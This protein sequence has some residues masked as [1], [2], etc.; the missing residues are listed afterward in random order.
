MRS[1]ASTDGAWPPARRTAEAD[2]PCGP[3]DQPPLD[4]RAAR[5]LVPRVERRVDP[6]EHRLAEQRRDDDR[7][8]EVG[9]V[10]RMVEVDGV[11][12]VDA[13]ELV[14]CGGRVAERPIEVDR[15]DDGFEFGRGHAGERSGHPPLLHRF[16][17]EL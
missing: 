12:Q 16:L 15:A 17:K 7:A 6:G 4:Q 2:P 11:V 9:E 14:Q 8:V 5:A 1:F 13:V 3:V 10:A